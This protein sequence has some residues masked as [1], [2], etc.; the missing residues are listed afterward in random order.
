[1]VV[2]NAR[3]LETLSLER[4]VFD[5]IKIV[6][7]DLNVDYVLRGQFWHCRR[8]NVVD[9]CS[10]RR[11]SQQSRLQGHEVSRPTCSR[12]YDHDAH[13]CGQDDV[14]GLDRQWPQHDWA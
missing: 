13:G 7:R 1:M 8:S 12:R 14:I 10:G 2:Q 11:G 3:A 9:I 5:S 6:Y 4:G